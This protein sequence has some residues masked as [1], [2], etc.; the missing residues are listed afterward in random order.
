MITANFA[1]MPSQIVI[2]SNSLTPLTVNRLGYGT[3]RLT[4]PEI[5]G[6]P[7]DRNEAKNILRR[8][9]ELGVN[10]LD[11]SDY[12]GP[13]VTT[14]LIAEALHPYTED[15]VICTKVGA[16]RGADKGWFNY[17]APEELREAIDD[18]LMRMKLE[19]LH[20]VH[21]R[22]MPGA[23]RVPFKESLDAM[24]DL[25]KEGKILH[26]GLSNVSPDELITGMQMGDIA[27]VQNLF[28]YHQRGDLTNAH[29][30][31]RGAG[32]LLKICE[33]HS[34]PLM[35]YFSLLTSIKVDNDKIGELAQ[36]HGVTKAAMNIAWQLHLSP[37]IL[38][39]PGTSSMAHLEDNLSAAAIRL[40]PEEMAFLG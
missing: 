5:W 7:A 18:N 9:V 36:R 32:A 19:Q 8:A 40:T 29:G 3:M 6:E 21:F 33:Q 28:G 26:V 37:W 2:G 31:S 20:V 24:F 13:Y 39:I 1:A 17:A 14:R 38:P 16:K 27:T 4:G 22:V 12:Y 35:P 10:F 25:Q 30:T 34:I 11:T 23:Q 15:L